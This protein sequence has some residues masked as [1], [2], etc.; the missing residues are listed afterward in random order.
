MKD[1]AGQ[2]RCAIISI[3]I[4]VAIRNFFWK[5][6]EVA[7]VAK[8]HPTQKGRYSCALAWPSQALSQPVDSDNLPTA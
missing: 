2:V 1:E 3:A 7:A 5:A 8:S 6:D 4:A